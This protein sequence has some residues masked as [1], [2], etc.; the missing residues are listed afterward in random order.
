MN[1]G[2]GSLIVKEKMPNR[3]AGMFVGTRGW[4]WTRAGS[5]P[6]VFQGPRDKSR[7][8]TAR[9]G[10]WTNGQATRC[11]SLHCARKQVPVVSWYS[12]GS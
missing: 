4:S 3:A 5:S 9:E 7:P 10:S 12:M 11:C 8:S 1:M 6:C 2:F